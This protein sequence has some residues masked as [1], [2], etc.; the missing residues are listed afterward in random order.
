MVDDTNK[1]QREVPP[2]DSSLIGPLPLIPVRMLRLEDAI[3]KI[4]NHKEDHV[5]FLDLGPAEEVRP[6]ILSIGLPFAPAVHEP[7]IV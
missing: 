1:T 2:E 7:V 4:I 6:K 3:N 5:L